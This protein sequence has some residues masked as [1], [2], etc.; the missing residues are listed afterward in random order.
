MIIKNQ[1]ENETGFYDKIYLHVL[2]VI[3]K[4]VLK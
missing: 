3:Y 4:G 2:N 1:N